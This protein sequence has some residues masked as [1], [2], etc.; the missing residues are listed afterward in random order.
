MYECTHTHTWTHACTPTH[1]HQ[2]PPTHMQ[3]YTHAHTHTHSHVYASHA[4]TPPH[5]DMLTYI[6]IHTHVH[7]SPTHALSTPHMQTC[8]HTYLY[9]HTHTYPCACIPPHTP[10]TLPTCR[11]AHL[12]THT[13]TH[14]FVGLVWTFSLTSGKLFQD[15]DG[16]QE[17]SENGNSKDENIQQK[18]PSKVVSNFFQNYKKNR[19]TFELSYVEGSLEIGGKDT[20]HMVCG[21]YVS[22]YSQHLRI[23]TPVVLKFMCMYGWL[24]AWHT[25]GR[26]RTT[27]RSWFS[28]AMDVTGNPG[29]QSWQQTPVPA[30]PYCFFS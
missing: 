12:H 21:L 23:L 7:A 10:S 2:A 9:T 19:T 3:T 20:G 27:C 28:L 15:E 29:F 14:S 11:H 16:F 1:I 8:A 30:E 24:G 26:W 17:L 6:F 5:A 25:W 22:A 13:H 4:S 18:L